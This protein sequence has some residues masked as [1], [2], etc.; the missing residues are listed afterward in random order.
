MK[1]LLVL[2]GIVIALIVLAYLGLQ[3]PPKPFPAFPQRTPALNTVPLPAGLPAPVER[4]YRQIYGE[5]VPVIE[6][7]VI[8]G[9]LAMRFNGLPMQGQ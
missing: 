8:T 4:F 2:M 7:A 9:R 1:I 3:I 5:Q 6:S